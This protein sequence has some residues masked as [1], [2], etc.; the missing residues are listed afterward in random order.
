MTKS[1]EN[2]EF[3]SENTYPWIFTFSWFNGAAR[4]TFRNIYDNTKLTAPKDAARMGD[5]FPFENWPM[6]ARS[7]I[8]NHGSEPEQERLF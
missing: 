3:I 1:S 6:F 2:F 5:I 8:P 7:L 4:V